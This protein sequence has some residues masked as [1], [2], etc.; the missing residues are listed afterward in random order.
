VSA[1]CSVSVEIYSALKPLTVF[2]SEMEFKSWFSKLLLCG[3]NKYLVNYYQIF[4]SMLVAAKVGIKSSSFKSY[5]NN[6]DFSHNILVVH[7]K[8][9]K[10]SCVFPYRDQSVYMWFCLILFV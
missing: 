4:E 3:F 5:V 2:E 1:P 7:T 6:L 8:I 9:T 10:G